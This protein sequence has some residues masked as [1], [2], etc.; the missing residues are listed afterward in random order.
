MCRKSSKRKLG[1]W[2]VLSDL[3]VTDENTLGDALEALILANE[4]TKPKKALPARNK[5]L[6][7]NQHNGTVLGGTHAVKNSN[8]HLREVG[9]EI[10]PGQGMP[11]LCLAVMQPG[12][13]PR[14]YARR[15]CASCGDRCGRCCFERVLPFLW[16]FV[17]K[18]WKDWAE[19]QFGQWQ[20]YL[21]CLRWTI[22]MAWQ[23]RDDFF[24]S[25]KSAVVSDIWSPGLPPPNKA[26]DVRNELRPFSYALITV[27][28]YCFWEVACNMM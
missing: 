7:L 5:L 16:R 17:P 20:F 3:G 9:V 10:I 19:P 13:S 23:E 26:K 1:P 2:V 8:R 14:V 11:K 18:K 25:A 15:C 12:R 22:G 4:K 27:M 28:L 24:R 21:I 6:V